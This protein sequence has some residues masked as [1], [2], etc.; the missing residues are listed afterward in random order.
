VGALLLAARSAAGAAPWPI[1]LAGV[2][3]LVILLLRATVDLNIWR[4]N[5][6]VLTWAGAAVALVATL[7]LFRGVATALWNTWRSGILTEVMRTTLHI[8]TMVFVI[9]LGA[10][11]FSMVFRSLGGD[12]IVHDVLHNLPG[13]RM[14]AVLLVMA[15]MFALGFFLDYIEIIFVVVP[16]VAPV[17]LTMGVDPVW[18]GVLISVNLQTSFLT[19]PF[20]FALFYLRGVAP[21]SVTTGDIYW[22]I[23][24]FVAIQLVGLALLILFPGIGTWLPSVL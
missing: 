20:G 21:P 6:S 22:G 5:I 7:A 4:D 10:S 18:L 23:V 19:P 24:P 17:L 2:A 3:A 8:S 12:A 15:L 16:I 11:V 9:L 1:R 14:A 13:G